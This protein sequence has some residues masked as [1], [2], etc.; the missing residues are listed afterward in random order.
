MPDTVDPA[1]EDTFINRFGLNATD[2]GFFSGVSFGQCDPS[3]RPSLE[4][5]ESAKAT[6][7][8]DL[9]LYDE[10]VDPE[11]SCTSPAFYR[12]MIGWAQNLHRADVGSWSVAGTLGDSPRAAKAASFAQLELF[13]RR[14][15]SGIRTSS[16]N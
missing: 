5:I 12:A 10:T 2:L 6:H 7:Q 14:G 13:L 8:P 3:E 9:Y 15:G 4:A 11:S 1:A 16:V